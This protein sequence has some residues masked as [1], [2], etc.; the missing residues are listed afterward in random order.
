MSQNGSDTKLR[1]AGNTRVLAVANSAS[2]SILQFTAWKKSIATELAR[3]ADWL[4][5]RDHL[6]HWEKL[7]REQ[8]YFALDRVRLLIMGEFSRGKTELI[9]ALL[10]RHFNF[11]LF[12]TRVGRTT[13]CPVELFYDDDNAPYLKLL[14]IDTRANQKSVADY[15]K[16][17]EAWYHLNLDVNDPDSIKQILREVARTREVS[18]HEAQDLGFQLEFLEASISQPG[19]VHIPAWR[20]ALINLEHPLL[21]TGLSFV[22]TP[23]INAPGL[24][25]DLIDEI[26]ADAQGMLFLTSVETG[27]TASDYSLWNQK[28]APV[29]RD[30]H[31]ALFAVINKIDLLETDEESVVESVERLIRITA[32]QLKIPRNHVLPVS[33]KHGLR[34]Y[35]QQ[36]VTRLRRSGL[37]H[38]EDFL[39]PAVVTTRER[40]L[41]DEVINHILTDIRHFQDTTG[42]E[43][44]QLQVEQTQFQANQQHLSDDY[45]RARALLA[46]DQHRLQQRIVS[47]DDQRQGIDSTINRLSVLIGKSRFDSHLVRAQSVLGSTPTLT[48]AAS[49]IGVMISGLRLDFKRVRADMEILPSQAQRIH[50]DMGLVGIQLPLLDMDDVLGRVANLEAKYSLYRE[51]NGDAAKIFE[52]S[53]LPEIRGL[54]QTL[55]SQISQWQ[56]AVLIPVTQELNQQQQALDGRQKVIQEMNTFIQER[57]Q[58]LAFIQQR[59]PQ[60]TADTEFL[61]ELIFR[62]EPVELA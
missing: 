2:K 25:S 30:N 26:M 33:A 12:P 17:P 62:L 42:Q 37:A 45:E 60:L 56:S 44:R 3:Y 54:Y 49:A 22:D 16:Q 24:E 20:H 39:I 13:M 35:L 50:R 11:R 47:V 53:F 19:Y 28:I 55:E 38:L 43:L 27:V 52:Q 21:K 7:S 57:R 40:L 18:T 34:S 6:A 36:D 15:R 31:I 46:D 29:S 1:S 4:K 61:D 5:Q 10:G 58:R 41:T 51:G 14:P 9:N 23:G 8:E 32:Q 48:T 59:L